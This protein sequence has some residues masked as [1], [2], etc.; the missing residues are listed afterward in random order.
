MNLK[1]L[2]NKHSCKSS[3][4]KCGFQ[5]KQCEYYCIEPFGHTESGDKSTESH[6]CYHGNIKHSSIHVINEDFNL[7]YA[8]VKKENKIY[9]LT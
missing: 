8:K 6:F 5:C 4:H 2:G 3:F 7:S 1:H 9:K